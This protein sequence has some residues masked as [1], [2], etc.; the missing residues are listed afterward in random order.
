MTFYVRQG[1]LYEAGSLREGGWE[2]GNKSNLREPYSL[3]S[4]TFLTQEISV[5]LFLIQAYN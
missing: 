4:Y 2:Q 3:S 5:H 1:A